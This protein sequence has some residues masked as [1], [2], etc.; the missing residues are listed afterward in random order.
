MGKW[1]GEKDPKKYVLFILA[2]CPTH[3]F[4]GTVGTLLSKD[5]LTS[6][7]LL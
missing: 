7:S 1:G 2:Q 6:E 3:F 5:R 4:L